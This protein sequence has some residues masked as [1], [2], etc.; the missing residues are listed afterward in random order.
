MKTRLSQNN[1]LEAGATPL[2]YPSMT[3]RPE[4]Q[5]AFIRKVYAILTFQI[6]LTIP[7][8][9]TVYFNPA[10]AV[11]L[12]E[13]WLGW[14]LKQTI[15]ITSLAVLVAMVFCSKHHQ[16]NYVLLGAFTICEAL[17]V[18][19]LEAVILTAVIFL[20][21]TLYT[22][23]AARRGHDFNFLGP[24][25][26]ASLLALLVFGVIQ[27]FVLNCMYPAS[28]LSLLNLNLFHCRNVF[29][30]IRNFKSWVNNTF[31]WILLQIFLPL[32]KTS[33]MIYGIVG[34]LIFCGYIVHDTDELIKHYEYDEYI[35]AA[36]DLYL[37]LLNLFLRFL[38]LMKD[39]ESSDDA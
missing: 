19:G 28:R 21:L 20:S 23:C 17:M 31:I 10:I 11:F 22:F 37:D 8:V 30:Y 32:G 27:V 18:G 33:H 26:F 1:D 14:F 13:T 3:G 34:I 16:L 9:A 38:E 39:A 4:F 36:I 5:W 7:I 29:N 6:L 15:I 35:L 12:I 2:L 25:L 24:F